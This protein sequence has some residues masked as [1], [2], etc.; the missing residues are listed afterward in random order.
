MAKEKKENNIQS[1]L[2]KMEWEG[3]IEGIIHYGWSAEE[4]HGDKKLAQLYK[5]AFKA[6][7]ELHNYLDDTYPGNQVSSTPE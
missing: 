7:V 5:K 2:D 1:F 6:F 3:G 4:I